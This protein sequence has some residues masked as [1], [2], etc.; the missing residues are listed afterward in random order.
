MVRVNRQ[1][2]GDCVVWMIDFIGAHSTHVSFP[3]LAKFCSANLIV[4]PKRPNYG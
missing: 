3:I 1:T 2:D 4:W